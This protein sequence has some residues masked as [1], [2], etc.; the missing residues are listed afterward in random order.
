MRLA[1]E[2]AQLRYPPLCLLPSP[3]PSSSPNSL[4][5]NIIVSAT[6]CCIGRSTLSL[7]SAVR[8]PPHER[9]RTSARQGRAR[10]LRAGPPPARRRTRDRSATA[11]AAPSCTRS[12]ASGGSAKTGRER[13]SRGR[14]ATLLAPPSHKRGIGETAAPFVECW[15]GARGS[16]GG[17]RVR[18]SVAA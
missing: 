3:P 13:R 1:G 6:H 9:G 14:S 4:H 10:R 17:G 5:H 2:V 8:R 7:R 18:R 11:R 12:S 15:G 16:S